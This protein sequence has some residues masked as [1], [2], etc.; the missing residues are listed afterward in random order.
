VT[1]GTGAQT[2]LKAGQLLSTGQGKAEVLLSPGVFLRV[3]SDSG[4]RM[5][6]PELVAPRVEITRGEA[7]VEV[8]RK[9]DEARLQI[10]ERNA[11]ASIL[12]KGL[13]RFDADRGLM[14]VLDGKLKLVENGQSKE[15][16]KGR[17][18][19]LNGGTAPQVASFDRKAE[20]DLYAWSKIRSGYLA[21]VNASTARY[22]YNGYR[23]FAGAGWYWSPYF[24][25]WSWLPGDGY[26]YSPFG[27]PF[28]SPGYVVYAPY[29]R[30]FTGFRGRATIPGQSG[31]TGFR[32]G[33]SGRTLG[34]G[35]VAPHAM[36][37]GGGVRR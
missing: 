22:V 30:G 17:E 11:E 13:Y 24:S 3:G 18:F 10:V 36:L 29:Y 20:D 15:I 14:Q 35:G 26:Y 34:H 1:P 25:S 7:M 8:D 5:V 4:I 27:Y 19:V 33:V 6:S 37:P 2:V 12:K 9:P 21:E 28:I 23:P 32:G 31:A 16:G